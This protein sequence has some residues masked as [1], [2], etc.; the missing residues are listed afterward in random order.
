MC[1]EECDKLLIISQLPPP[2]NVKSSQELK[3]QKDSKGLKG[4]TDTI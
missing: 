2:Q 3:L 4:E 1:I